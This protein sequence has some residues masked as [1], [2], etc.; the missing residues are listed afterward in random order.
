MSLIP[1]NNHSKQQR[2]IILICNNESYALALFGEK[3]KK[4]VR[5]K[6]IIHYDHHRGVYY[7]NN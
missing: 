6:N 1:V 4:K 5:N 2:S 3:Y 7:Q